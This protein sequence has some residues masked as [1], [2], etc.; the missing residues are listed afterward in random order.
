M[1]IE[2][3]K[4]KGAGVGVQWVIQNMLDKLQKES[5]IRVPETKA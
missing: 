1:R 3:W 2:E 4:I 5:L